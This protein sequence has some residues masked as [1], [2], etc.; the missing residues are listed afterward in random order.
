MV[1]LR[2]TNN[3]AG[4]FILSVIILGF[5][6]LGCSGTHNQIIHGFSSPESVIMDPQGD[7]FYVSNVGEVLDPSAK[8]G[9]GYIS[10]LSL[11]GK[12]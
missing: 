1:N 8:D 5:V 12:I 3:I 6:A 9:D 2:K 10:R 7:Y 11:S 4:I